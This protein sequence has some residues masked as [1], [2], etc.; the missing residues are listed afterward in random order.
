[1]VAAAATADIYNMAHSVDDNKLMP[2]GW[3][4]LIFQKR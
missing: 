1:M 3:K 4:N 2:V